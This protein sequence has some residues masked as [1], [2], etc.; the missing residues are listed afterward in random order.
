[1][2]ILFYVYVKFAM[3]ASYHSRRF[4]R[5]NEMLESGEILFSTKSN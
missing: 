5:I 1:M 3:N 4:D 2:P